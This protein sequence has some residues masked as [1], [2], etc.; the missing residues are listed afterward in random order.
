MTVKALSLTFEALNLKT[1]PQLQALFGQKGACG[2][3]WCMTPRLPSSAYNQNKGE[4]NKKKLH[5]LIKSGEPLGVIA[6]HGQQPVA[7]CSISPKTRL[8][9][10][11]NSRLM[12]LTS[13]E[14]CWSIVCLFIA[15]NYR[16]RGVSGAVIRAAANYA[17][18]AGAK[19]VEAYPLINRTEDIPDAFAWNG[20]WKS[21]EK[22]GFRLIKQVS[23]T[24][25]I[26][27]LQ[28]LIHSGDAS[29]D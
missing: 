21:Y 6:F 27:Q 19:I 8:M 28:A 26:V 2:G 10:M 17:F 4:G 1:W 11:R 5:E 29:P 3:C 18:S 7:W 9:Q 14:Q 25:A 16:R 13:D 22:V 24:R 20:I 23:E 12:K 15:K